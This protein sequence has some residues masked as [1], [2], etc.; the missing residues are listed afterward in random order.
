MFKK[1]TWIFFLFILII[2]FAATFALSVIAK[3]DQI[4]KSQYYEVSNE[5]FNNITTIVKREQWKQLRTANILAKNKINGTF[6]ATTDNLGII[7]VPFNTHNKSINDKIIFRL[8]E[9]AKK[10]WYYQ[11]AYNT[12]QF[13][14]DI[15]FPFG[16]PIIKNSKNISYMFEIESLEGN[17]SEPYSLSKNNPYFFTKYKFSK[18]ELSNN[19]SIL[20]KFFTAKTSEQLSLLTDREIVK[21]FLLSTFVLFILM[22]LIAKLKEIWAVKDL[23][24]KSS[25]KFI[26]ELLHL[27]NIKTKEYERN[28]VLFG[29][30]I[31]FSIIAFIILLTG[32][33]SFPLTGQ[34]K[35]I[36]YLS[37]LIPSVAL[38]LNYVKKEWFNKG[39]ILVIA[40][41]L[42]SSLLTLSFISYGFPSWLGVAGALL[43]GCCLA[44]LPIMRY[45]SFI[46]AGTMVFL[47]GINSLVFI[48]AYGWSGFIWTVSVI[49]VVLYTFLFSLLNHNHITSWIRIN[50]ISFILLLIISSLFALRSDSFSLGPSEYHWN[51]F[52]AVIQTLHSGGELLWSAPSQYGFLNILLPSLLPWTSRSSFY[53]F[54]AILFFASTLIIIRTIYMYFSRSASFISIA[55]TSLSLF[56]FADPGIMGPTFYP[57]SSAVRFFCSY[58]LIYTALLEYKRGS[59]L[60][61]G[62]KWFVTGSYILGAFWSAES[63]LTC[64]AIYAVY[65]LSS[66][67]SLLNLKGIKSAFRFLFINILVVLIAFTVFNLLYL[68][69]TRH[70]PDWSMYFMFVFTYA[71]GF[72]EISI[73]PWGIHWAVIIVLSGIVLILWR[74]YSARKYNEW[75]IVAVCFITLW[76]LTSYYVGR[77][78]T[79]NLTAILPLI[80]YI[81]IIMS[82]VLMES[83]FFSYRLL[84]NAV[85]LPWI[86]VGVIGGFG[87]P[88]FIDNLPKFKYAEDVN[89]KSFKPD[90]ELKSLLVS[91]GALNGARIVYYGYPYNNPIIPNKRGDFTELLAGMPMPLTL[92]EE[93]TSEQ[94]REII[95]KRFMNKIKG[96][97]FFIYQKNEGSTRLVSWEKFLD[98]KYFVEKKDTG[99][100]TYGVFLVKRK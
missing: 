14:N 60:N 64:T 94:K 10:D 38:S 18:S 73:A 8:K 6:T 70:F 93:P 51:Y 45:F 57:S 32:I 95:M 76:A 83:K 67:I 34:R 48:N 19:P 89:S 23:L 24:L 4:N 41:L 43:I 44:I 28:D 2:S 99:S 65:L 58:L 84:L 3:N 90:E 97:V 66:A 7:S 74:L 30:L 39:Y 63:F 29:F 100:G 47:F 69:I 5:Q 9:E 46:F 53:I 98:Q 75:V 33:L 16:F 31:T 77:A 61:G 82:S 59:I 71:N 92:L 12:N 15:P 36:P 79:N 52:T 56:Y 85:F 54:Q 50:R 37:I 25:K 91:L 81:F 96:N 80:F 11:G 55:L 27:Q 21:I 1:T 49:V 35:W 13:Q 68:A 20:L 78:A 88:L 72:G 17:S 86:I 62:V 22:V 26:A 87:N 42:S 40:G